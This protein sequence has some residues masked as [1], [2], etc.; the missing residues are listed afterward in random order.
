MHCVDPQGY[1]E[2]NFAFKGHRNANWRRPASRGHRGHDHG[3]QVIVHLCRRVDHA[4]TC[5]P[6]LAADSRIE[7]REPDI[8]SLYQAS[9][10]SPALPNSGHTSLSS[11][12]AAWLYRKC[13]RFV[14]LSFRGSESRGTAQ[15]AGMAFCVHRLTA[16]SSAR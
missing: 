10:E 2:F 5:L 12:C 8:A 11:P 14:L 7:C 1:L 6:E 13:C 4:R 15:V 16:R 9:S 3:A